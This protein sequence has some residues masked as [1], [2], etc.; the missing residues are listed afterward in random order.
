MEM[1]ENQEEKLLQTSKVFS[2]ERFPEEM[3]FTSGKWDF[4]YVSCSISL[5]VSHFLYYPLFLSRSCFATGTEINRTRRRKNDKV[6]LYEP[7]HII[8]TYNHPVTGS[9]LKKSLDKMGEKIN[10]FRLPSGRKG[11]NLIKKLIAYA[12]LE[13]FFF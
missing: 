13:G 3:C 2:S 7:P 9:Y 6:N 4:Q 8:S 1:T 11:E 10:I 12:E 5:P